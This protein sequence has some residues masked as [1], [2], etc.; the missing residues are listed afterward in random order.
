MG[1]PNGRPLPGPPLG[2]GGP[3]SGSAA[4]AR[5][6]C[7]PVGRNLRL[8]LAC[9]PN[10][11]WPRRRM[12]WMAQSEAQSSQWSTTTV[13]SGRPPQPQAH[14][15]P[16]RPSFSASWEPP[17][18]RRGIGTIALLPARCVSS[19]R[20]RLRRL[21]VSSVGNPVRGQK[22]TF[23][24][25]AS[26][27]DARDAGKSHVAPKFEALDLGRLE[28][29]RSGCTAVRTRRN[30]LSTPALYLSDRSTPLRVHRDGI[31]R[32]AS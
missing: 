30:R 31:P 16:L 24:L 12:V 15:R 17:L 13:A 3:R 19:S 18:R 23:R 21:V 22:S 28:T 25:V 32:V 27:L 1:F 14:G 8:G 9:R 26:S 4:G 7:S 20:L 11:V 5:A 29:T 10:R 6:N 2:E